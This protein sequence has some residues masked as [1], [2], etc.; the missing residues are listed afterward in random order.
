MLLTIIPSDNVTLIDGRPMIFDLSGY[1]SLNGLHAVQ[2]NDTKGHIEFIN[3][4]DTPFR[5]N[6][7]ITS[8]ALY[9]DIIDAWY[10]MEAIAPPPAVMQPPPQP[11]DA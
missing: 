8:I 9:Q 2:W 1:G 11:P 10:A 6:Q 5:A 7:K 3:V 4:E